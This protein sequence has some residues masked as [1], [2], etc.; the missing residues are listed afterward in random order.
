[1]EK[2]PLIAI[3]THCH[4]NTGCPD[5]T[6]ERVTYSA[7]YEDLRVLE[8]AANIGPMF[9]S[10]FGSVLGTGHIE[11]ENEIM[12]RRSREEEDL[13]QWVVIDPRND[14]TMEQADRMLKQP[15]CVGI[16]LH[17][18][19]HQYLVEDYADKL[20]SLASKYHAAVQIH[21]EKTETYI[22][23]IADRFP[24]VTFIM[25]HLA[26]PT[27]VDA[28]EQAKHGNVYAD[29]SGNASS[30]NLVIEYAVNRVGSERIL[31]GTDTYAPGFQRG[32]VEY[33]MISQQD[34]ENILRNNALRLFG[35]II[36]L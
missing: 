8:N 10:T 6:K 20:F 23:P 18:A 21:P 31:F 13:Y 14:R 1:M 24:E 15:K 30:Q 2:L 12:Y 26:G 32:R 35:H 33:A 36:N 4:F 16:K 9:C 5:D 11:E 17:P 19:N 27:W 3:D 25:A 28:I 22:V 34:K 7:Q 29:T